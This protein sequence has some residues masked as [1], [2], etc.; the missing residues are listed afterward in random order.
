MKAALQEL[1]DAKAA[2]EEDSTDED[3]A[4][5]TE[6]TEEE[7]DTTLYENVLKSSLPSALSDWIVED[8]R[9]AGDTTYLAADNDAGYYVVMFLDSTD[10]ADVGTVN[11]RHI[12][13]STT[14]GNITAEEAKEQI[15][16]LQAQYEEDPTEEHFAQ[17][18]EEHSTDTGSNTNGGLYENV[19]PGQMVDAFNDWIFDTS[20]KAGDTGIVETEYGCHLIYF[21]G[22]GQ[23]SYRDSLIVNAKTNEDYNTWYTGLT[24]AIT[25]TREVGT[26][27][28]NTGVSLQSS[29]STN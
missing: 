28:V 16:E 19:A 3:A 20:R 22:P 18:A 17:L 2:E 13:I 5:E 29:S 1:I 21:V 11:V 8:G 23:Y 26:K 9:Q 15:E 25:P 24:D 12:L 14:D 6:S 27:L 4:D 10:N 7:E